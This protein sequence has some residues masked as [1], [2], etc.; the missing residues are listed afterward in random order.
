[1]VQRTLGIIKPDA[2]SAGNAGNI[3]AR[4]E[5]EGFKIVAIKKIWLTPS[6]A[7]G[8]YEVHKDKLFFKDLVS[9]MTSGPCMPMVLEAED[10]ISRNR[11][12]MGATDSTKAEEGTLRNLYGT[13]IQCNAVHGSDAPETAEREIRF[14]FSEAELISSSMS[15]V[16]E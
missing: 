2:V 13:D 4:Y 5:K 12:I 10:A 1:M 7:A 14:F 6:Q 3:I 15:P 16:S 11:K 9:F 8:F